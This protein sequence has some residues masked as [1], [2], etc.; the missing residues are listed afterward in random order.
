MESEGKRRKTLQDEVRSLRQ[1]VKELEG[2]NE[3]LE[4]SHRRLQILFEKAPDAYYLSDLEGTFVDGNAAAERM[5]DCEENGLIGKNLLTLSLLSA[6]DRERAALLLERS[7]LEQPTGP[8]EFVLQRKDGSTITAEIRTHPVTVDGRPL[9]LGIVRDVSVRKG[10]EAALKQ[11]EER[12]RDLFDNAN[13]LIQSVAPDGRFEYVNAAWLRRLGYRREELEA[14]TLWDIIHPDSEPYCREVFDALLAGRPV[15]RIEATFVAKGG[16]RI[17][18]EG[19]VNCRFEGDRPVATRGI[20]RDVT[21]RKRFEERLALMARRDPLTGVFNRYA[22]EELLRLEAERSSR[23]EHPIG[24]LL[25]DVN[26]FKEINDRFGH[27]TGDKVLQSVARTIQDQVRGSD[28]IVRYGGDEF[29]VILLETDGETDLVKQRIIAEIARRNQAT[30]LVDFPVTLAIGSV[31]WDPAGE[32]SLEEVLSEAD[33]LMYE[34]KR[35]CS[36]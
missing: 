29:L 33:R 13:D 1:R 12:L 30:L 16:E 15:G 31:H 8:D 23:Y 9:V 34:D 28:V 11:S 21:E 10:V 20:F 3:M 5:I 32:R 4:E 14:L 19:G 2:R 6:A 24:F 36:A 7:R 18:V 27:L 17:Q 22:L 25:I 35:G 26:R